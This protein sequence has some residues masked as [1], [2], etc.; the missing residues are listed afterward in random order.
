ML[1]VSARILVKKWRVTMKRLVSII[2]AVV[3][4]IMSAC[5][6][7]DVPADVSTYFGFES[8][9]VTKGTSFNLNYYVRGNTGFD[10]VNFANVKTSLS[11][12]GFTINAI[13]AGDLVSD[14][15]I[16]IGS[17]FSTVAVTANSTITSDGVLLVF[18]LT[19]NE[20]GTVNFSISPALVR[21]GSE[22]F[23]V[24]TDSTTIKVEGS[25]QG[26]QSDS[27][28]IISYNANGG[29]GA[30]DSQTKEQGQPITLSDTVPTWSGH[31]FLGW[32]SSSTATTAE[33]EAGASF[34]VDQTLTLY[35]VWR[36]SSY[37]ISYN[38]NGGTGAPDAGTKQFNVNYT[39][40]GIKPTRTN[41]DFV[42]WSRTATGAAEFQPGDTYT[43]NASITLYAVWS[44]KTTTIKYDANGGSASIEDVKAEVGSSITLTSVIPTR[45]GYDFLGWSLDDAQGAVTH[46][47]GASYTAENKVVTFY[48]VWQLKTYTIGF[49]LNGGSGTFNNI[50]K[51][52]GVA[53][54]L[55]SA[56]P[57]KT[58]ASFLGW[59]ESS[60]A[61]TASYAAGA[62]FAKNANTTLYAVYKADPVYYTVTFYDEDGTTVLDTQNVLE[63]SVPVY[64]GETPVKAQTAQY[65]YSFS[66][67]D[68]PITAVSGE[69]TYKAVYTSA[70][71]SYTVKFVNYDGAVLQSSSVQ[72]GVTPAYAGATPTRA[73]T[74]GNVY[75]F[76]GWD[77]T[78]VAVTGDVTYTA[79]YSSQGQV[80]TVKFVDSDGTTELQTLSLE[81][82]E[83]PVYS[84]TTP[85]KES[86]AQYAYEF[87]GWDK[88]I[89]AVAGDAT[90]KAVYTATLRTYTVKFVDSDGTT[91][92][93]SSQVA[94]GAKPAY[95][96]QTPVK[97]ST[98]QYDYTFAGWDKT[99]A[100]VTGEVTYKAVYTSVLRSYTIK[101]VNSDGTTVLQSSSVK[102]GEM[103][104]YSGATPTKASTV[105]NIYTFAGWDKSVVPVTQ[106][107]TYT[108][109]YTTQGQ[110]YT[111]T[112]VDSDGTTV[113]QKLT[114]EYGE[115]PAYTA[116]TPTKAATA[117]YT[118]TFAGWNKT[119]AAVTGNAT[120]K[121][122]YTS[123][124][125][126]YTVKF[127]DSD[128]TTVLQ[129]STVEY[130]TVPVYTGATPAK[131]ATAKYTY[132]FAGWNKEIAA[133][134]NN[135]NYKAVYTSVLTKYAVHFVTGTSE[136][137]ADVVAEYGKSVPLPQTSLT[138]EGYNFMGWSLTSGGTV[139]A[140]DY[141]V[142]VKKETYV[143]ALWKIKTF[144][145]RYDGNGVLSAPAPQTKTYG[146]DLTLAGK[147]N[148]SGGYIFV[149]WSEDKNARTAEYQAKGIFT[150]NADTTL[151][152]IWAEEAY[153]ITF[154]ANGGTNAPASKIKAKG[155]PLALT[156]TNKEIPLKSGYTC[157]GWATS[158]EEANAKQV[159][160]P[161]ILTEYLDIDADITLYA[162]WDRN[163]FTDVNPS[164]WAGRYIAYVNFRQA[165]T[166]K[167]ST[168]FGANDELIRADMVTLLWKLEGKPSVETEKQPFEDV[169][170]DRYF[171]SSV[172]W[173]K[174]NGLVTGETPTIFNPQKSISRQDFILI[175][176]R[177]AANYK[178]IDVSVKNAKAYLEKEDAAN[179]ARYARTAVNWGYSVGLIGQGS[180]LN[181]Q[182]SISRAEAATIIAR[183]LETFK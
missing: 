173:A 31:D 116:E 6:V 60:T 171:T 87:A 74:V 47:S 122:V 59:S 175:I 178:G 67:W 84:G 159:R 115:T 53:V 68:K 35:A 104:V 32:A 133:V 126:K 151:Y 145:I 132:T 33:Y 79:T 100:A 106:N 143:Y 40:S 61:T 139:L 163:R 167:N 77:K 8:K 131:A 22:Y 34:Y 1:Q 123:T 73:S 23:R 125:N 158:K 182:N 45:D 14:K 69:A 66:G 25:G 15:E 18:N 120:Y 54:N 39:I 16:T 64:G 75:T 136:K 49:D 62:S 12:Y 21:L 92:L 111:V 154:D 110:V 76:A 180:P 174:E 27:S 36:Q 146:K 80:Y 43:E 157:L 5:Q 128:G 124:V 13:S 117:K 118:Y 72:Y 169:G 162:V 161:I 141:E 46:A 30:P 172:I 44:K 108:A 55:P 113:L 11:A 2:M 144:K 17:K 19:A 90:Y 58:G 42:G 41:Y 107:A 10:S 4:I 177:Y 50:T 70:L 78:I 20:T 95:G 88:E 164:G 150:K 24:G 165:M 7:Y 37:T 71:R 176:Y 183:F 105:Q 156:F 135:A 142:V 81:Y 48:A 26:V 97:K 51:S 137:I 56:S 29:T 103:P 168:F 121:A 82:G 170:L 57:V 85:T 127:L 91:V 155:Q 94:Y 99:I 138:K 140:G 129:S 3:L 38:P 101:F 152:A 130:G 96:G 119:I 28:Y 179:V 102:Y 112:F 153:T 65:T 160:Y 166:G 83:T 114:M 148:R 89:T 93:Q 86:T 181:P 52:H 149:G 98:A 147:M 109:T 9:T 63:G 134:K